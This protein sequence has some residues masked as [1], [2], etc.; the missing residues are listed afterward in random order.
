MGDTDYAKA[1]SM[2]ISNDPPGGLTEAGK[3]GGFKVVQSDIHQV[4]YGA[5]SEG[6]C[7]AVITGQDYPPRVAIQGLEEI[8]NIFSSQFASKV[9][10]HDAKEGS[11]TKKG[12]KVLSTFCEKYDTPENADKIQQVLSKVDKMKSGMQDNLHNMLK[13]T[14]SANNLANKSNELHEQAKVFKERAKTVKKDMQWKN[15]KVA[16]IITCIVGI[17]VTILLVTLIP[18]NVIYCIFPM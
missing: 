8:S 2:I 1:V 5:D 6:I 10:V 14:E 4:V 18:S 17:V 7:Y 11:L 16:I 13:N 12:K 9:I 3:L 15:L